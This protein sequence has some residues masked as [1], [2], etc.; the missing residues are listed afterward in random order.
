MKNLNTYITESLDVEKLKHLEHAEDHIIHGGH[1]GVAHAHDTL[2]DVFNELQGKKTGTK[3]TQK[4]DGAPSIVFGIDPKTK[5]F[6]VASKSAF[7]K[8]PKLNFTPEDIEKN[9]GHA[10]GLVEKLKAALEHLP[11]VMPK[12]GGVY[13]GDLMYTS[14]DV[15][16]NGDSYSFTPNTITYTTDKNSAQ[17]RAVKNA[18]LGLVVHTQYKGKNLE[19]MKADFNVDQSGFKQDPNVHMINPEVGET[20]MTPMEKKKYEKHIESAE[21]LYAGMD[22]EVFDVLD[23]HDITLKTYIND[24][25]R[26]G[27]WNNADSDGY[28]SS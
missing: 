9:H 16:D 20:S 17:G 24:L 12:H 19:D 14:N 22:P 5:K 27:T 23:G 15:T 13:Q 28:V 21:Q 25:V 26:K 10:P 3:I 4:Y 18:K 1:E 8:N 2:T 7:N 6:F 11:S